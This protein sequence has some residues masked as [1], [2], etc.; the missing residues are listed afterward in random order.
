MDNDY[1]LELK[2]QE[3]IL[4]KGIKIYQPTLEEIQHNFGLEKFYTIL[5][6]FVSTIDCFNFKTTKDIESIDLFSDILCHIKEM[7]DNICIA[8]QFFFKKDCVRII[9]DKIVVIENDKI[10]TI[11]DRDDFYNIAKIIRLIT[12][13]KVIEIEKPPEGLSAR[14]LDIWTKLHEG[15]KRDAERNAVHIYDVLNVCE[16]GGNFHIPMSE[17]KTWTLWTIMNCYNAVV[18]LRIYDNEFSKYLV[19]GDG[20]NIS[21]DKYWHSVL[22]IH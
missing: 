17:I 13:K 7:N 10:T 1:F 4:Y 3:P 12:A 5:I 19:N 9:D 6:P 8:L 20:K 11:L 2:M 22:M 18:G 21:N 14:K 16:F 15:R